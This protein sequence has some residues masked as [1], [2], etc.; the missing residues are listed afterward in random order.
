[1]LVPRYFE[2][3]S[4]LHLGTLPARAYYIPDSGIPR[5]VVDREASDR[6]QLLNATWRFSYVASLHEVTA[7]FWEPGFAAADFDE[8]PVPSSWQHLGYDLH[9]YT[10]IRYPIPLDPPHVPQDNPAGMYLHDFTYTPTPEAPCVTLNFEGVD[11]CCYVWLNGTFVGYSQVSHATCEFDVT[12]ALRPGSNRLAVLV[13][14]WCDGTYLEDQDKFRTSGIFRDVYLLKRPAGAIFDYF[15]TTTLG[16]DVCTV[17]VRATFRGGETPTQVTL[18]DAAGAPVAAAGLAPTV[19]EHYT[20]AAQ[21]T[22]SDPHLWSAEDPYLYGLS[23]TSEHEV[24]RDQVGL[25]QVSADGPVLLFNGAPVKLRGVNRHD[26]DPVTGPVVDLDH[27]RRDLDLMKQHNINAIR[28]AHYP[29]APQFYQLCDQYGF[30]VMSEA[31]NES[32]GTQMQYLADE[33]WD[34]VVEQWNKRI[35]DNPEWTAATLD[36]MQLCVHR[37]KNRPCIF[38]W[39]AGNEGGFG[40]T[41][42]TA[43]AWVKGFDPS[44]VTHYESAYYRSHDREY[45]YSA[46]DLYSRMYPGLD[47]I[48]A[49]LASDPDKPFLLVEYCHAMGNGPGDVADYWRLIYNDERLC[50]GF[51]WEWCDHA[52]RDGES[53]DGR[54]VFLYGGDHGEAIHDGNFC[55]DGLISPDRVPHTGLLEVANV[56]RPA[57]VEDLDLPSGRITLRNLLDFTDLGGYLKVNY[58]LTCDGEVIDAGEV[59]L[60]G[61]VPPRTTVTA[62]LALTPPTAGRCH[63][64]VTYRLRRAD[65]VLSAG[66]VLGFDEL[67]VTTADPRPT[68]AAAILDAPPRGRC[69]ETS[70]EGP[71]LWVSGDGFE[72]CFDVRTAMPSRLRTGGGELLERAAELNIWRAPTDN[73]RIIEAQWRRA[74]YHQATARAYRCAARVE[75]V[76]VFI[77]AELAVVAAAVQ[78]IVRGSVVWRVAGDGALTLRL[79]AKREPEF[80]ALP[81]FG[82]RLFLPEDLAEVSYFG[83]GPHESYV[84]KHQASRY[85]W[86][87]AGVDDLFVNYLRPQEN[88]SH[89]GCDLVTL[90]GHQAG[91][92]IASARPM[93]FNASRYTQEAL[94]AMPRDVE[95]VPSGHTILC[96]DAAMAGI[97]SQSCGP[98]LQPCYQVPAEVALDMRLVAYAEPNNPPTNEA[99]R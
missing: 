80:P 11:S 18:T 60:P 3:L 98:A 26:S 43:L 40:V 92:T 97:G 81:R 74:R 10:N 88:G 19:D 23:L 30:Y 31:D 15:T 4:L 59:P 33:A 73:D 14:K 62:P 55:V 24:I 89:A 56:L 17:K 51:V 86:Y 34:N 79:R 68:R 7:P 96:L 25:R 49:Y 37:E 32:H 41:F 57:R 84:D 2:D 85:G 47:E 13:L 48:E 22:V 36:R 53:S 42:E 9:Q 39:S 77:E 27:M 6:F 69:P 78:P 64:T 12:E 63:L 83:L 71:Q 38:S 70:Q 75:G 90:T 91:L 61:P 72:Y 44:R 82:V 87:R 58:E 54:P 29:N 65:G 76:E 67:P 1:M 45:D 5:T 93:S 20:H 46:I 50:G 99:A 16:D 21:L 95:L 35:A 66:H 52:V 8:I 28:S 94:A